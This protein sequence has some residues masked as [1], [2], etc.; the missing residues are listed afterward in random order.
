MT[1]DSGSDAVEIPHNGFDILLTFA[2]HRDVALDF[3]ERYLDIKSLVNLFAIS[4]PFHLFVKRH[5]MEIINRLA[6]YNADESALIFP[7]RCYPKLCTDITNPR[8]Q[9]ASTRS[10]AAQT[11]KVPS[12]RWLQM[13]I[14]REHTVRNIMGAMLRVG[15]G[16]PKRCEPAI[17]KL[18]FIMDIPDNKRRQW[19]IENRNIWEDIDVFF[20]VLFI[21]QL[22]VVLKKK[23]TTINGRMFRLLLAQPTLTELWDVLRNASLR[24]DFDALKAFVRWRYAPAEHETDMH[25]YGVPPNEIGALQFEGYGRAERNVILLR[26]DELVFR[27]MSKRQLNMGEMYKT[28]FLYGNPSRYHSRSTSHPVAWDSEMQLEAERLG[29]TWQSMVILDQPVGH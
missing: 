19:T 5:Y 16:L 20:A 15:H 18:W 12:F 24:T 17:K 28:I 14:Y 26:P 27:E 21:A 6:K 13:I 2:Y 23:R 11:N 22:D 9:P 10:A 7:A 4:K 3:I 1:P 25:V 8:R 29:V